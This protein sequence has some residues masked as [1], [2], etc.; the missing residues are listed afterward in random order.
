MV[1]LVAT[2]TVDSDKQLRSRM[3]SV[4]IPQPVVHVLFIHDGPK[5]ETPSPKSFRTSVQCCTFCV[6]LVSDMSLSTP[7]VNVSV[8]VRSDYDPDSSLA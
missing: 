8:F 4:L 3:A 2:F 6:V 1:L 7:A 5:P